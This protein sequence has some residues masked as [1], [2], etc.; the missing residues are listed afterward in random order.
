M[1]PKP[2]SRSRLPGWLGKLLLA[3]ASVL[4]TL[5]AADLLLLAVLG[6]VRVVENFYEPDARC[7]YRMRP[8]LVFE[9]AS[10]YHGYR[11]TVRTNALG[12]RGPDV[13]VPKPAGTYRVLLLG[14]S[15]TAGLEVNENETFAAVCVERLR[16]PR[17]VEVVN[18]GV[19]GYNLDNVRLV[20]NRY[21]REAAYLEPGDVETTLNRKLHWILPD[22][23][24]IVS[25][26]VN[27]GVPLLDSAPKSKLRL[28]LQQMAQDIARRTEGAAATADTPAAKPKGTGEPSKRGL[29]SLFTG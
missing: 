19:R 3:A 16:G 9:F 20:C 15:M 7:G 11:A 29:L 23:W 12:L 18:A 14:D 28:G 2:A 25:T 10:P 27:V 17:H 13:V 24:K 21:G 22:D 5:V 26:A 4:V 1:V 6:P 8:N